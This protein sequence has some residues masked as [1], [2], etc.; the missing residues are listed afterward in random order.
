MMFFAIIVMLANLAYLGLPAAVPGSLQ[1]THDLMERTEVTFAWKH[2]PVHDCSLPK[3]DRNPPEHDI[4]AADCLWLLNMITSNNGG[5]FELWNFDNSSYKPLLGHNTCVLAASH[6]VTQNTSDY[7]V[8]GNQDVAIILSMA[9]A[10]FQDDGYLPTVA[11][12][13]TC[14][15]NDVSLNLLIYNG[16]TGGSGGPV[17]ASTTTMLGYAWSNAT[18]TSTVPALP[19]VTELSLS[20]A[21]IPPS[22][23]VT[24]A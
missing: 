7:A 16:L 5:F 17:N 13:I 1:T 3:L 6:N 8:V 18:R 21:I 11:G 14:G 4:L 23:S 2:Y 20:S 10:N 19:S 24:S 15:R 12:N 9:L 22:P